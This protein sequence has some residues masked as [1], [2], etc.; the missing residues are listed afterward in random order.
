MSSQLKIFHLSNQNWDLSPPHGSLDWQNKSQ[1][2]INHCKRKEKHI[3]WIEPIVF[4]DRAVRL[5]FPPFSWGKGMPLIGQAVNT[6]IPAILPWAAWPIRG[7][8]FPHENGGKL[9]LTALFFRFFMMA[10]LI[11]YKRGQTKVVVKEVFKRSPR[12]KSQESWGS[13]RSATLLLIYSK[14]IFVTESWSWRIFS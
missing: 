12:T 6:I 9:S 1:A 11:L 3:L 4:L 14:E 2:S 10:P 5:S 8:P 13:N 7:I